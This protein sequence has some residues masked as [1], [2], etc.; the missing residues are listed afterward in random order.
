[1]DQ[2]SLSLFVFFYL[3]RIWLDS[4]PFGGNADYRC[5][6][7]YGGSREENSTGGVG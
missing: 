5:R 7:N 3:V 6:G 1:M 4:E 2:D